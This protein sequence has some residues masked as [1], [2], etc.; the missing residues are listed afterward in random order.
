MN[1]NKGRRLRVRDKVRFILIYLH[2]IQTCQVKKEDIR[3]LKVFFHYID[4]YGHCMVAVLETHSSI[5]NSKKEM[6]PSLKVF[7][8]NITLSNSKE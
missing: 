2:L 7:I 6:A 5:I 4:I 3:Y 1:N 8:K